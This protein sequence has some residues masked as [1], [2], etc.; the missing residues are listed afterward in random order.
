MRERIILA[1]GANGSELLK[2][3]AMH[4]V[5]CFN[6]RICSAPELAR[7]ALMRSGITITEEFISKREETVITANAIKGVDYFSTAT[8][9]DVQ[10]VSNAIRRLRSFV[11]DGEKEE[12]IIA[13]KLSLGSF[14]EKNSALVS[15]Y[16]NYMRQISEEKKIDTISLVRKAISECEPIEADYCVLDEFPLNPIEET[17]LS[18]LSKN[19]IQ[20]IELAALFGANDDTPIKINTY[21]RCYGASNEVETILADI[22]SGKSLDKC[23][24]AVTDPGTY[25]QLFFDYAILNDIPVSFGCGIPIINSNPAKLLKVYYH[26]IMGGFFGASAITS[27]LNSP[28]FDSSKL[29]GLYP[30]TDETFSWKTYIDVVKTIRLTNN[31]TDNDKRISDFVNSI[32]EEENIIGSEDIKDR[33]K[34]NEKKQCIPLLKVLS[35]ELSLPAEEFISKY[36]YIRKGSDT[37][38]Q[39]LLMRLDIAASKAIY[40]ELKI[41]RE[42]GVVQAT[43]DMIRN[44][45]KMSVSGERSEEGKLFVTSID[46]AMSVAR[47]NLF[48]A[49]LSASKYPES[50]IEN[51]LLLDEDI[52]LFGEKVD[53][54]TS[55]GRVKRKIDCLHALVKLARGLGSTIDIS[56]AG[57]NVSELK[58]DN[59]SSLIFEL[60][61]KE[62]GIN[63]TSKELEERIIKIDYF[64]PAISVTREVGK[65]Y[66]EGKK[67]L[68]YTPDANPVNSD[69]K[70]TLDK[71]YSPSTLDTFFGCP[72]AFMLGHI[73]GIPKP[74]EDKPFEI[75]SANELGTLAH[76]LMEILGNSDMSLEEFMKLSSDCFDRFVTQHPP[77]LVQGVENEKDQFLDM[78]ENAYKM[79]PHREVVLKE[80]DIS[81]VHETGVSL[82]GFPDRVEKLDDGSYLVV[83]FKSGKTISHVDDDINTCLQTMVY[84]YILEKNGFENVSGA[85]YRYIRL[86][87]TVSCRYDDKMKEDLSNMLDYFKQ[88]VEMADFPIN[89][90]AYEENREKGE[91]DPC[92]FCKYGLVCGK[93]QS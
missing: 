50:A 21:K 64:E 19:T 79:D 41:I 10:E 66:N 26:W 13:E 1:P 65:A 24:V 63:A 56:Y 86:G 78:M 47:E 74:D 38:T 33:C 37:N 53:H 17:F 6:L 45:L 3:L 58:K 30:E 5:N 90:K 82:H 91:K 27:L 87:Q 11:V 88:H 34:V 25:G 68:L 49:G 73:L 28:A 51:Y 59:A 48:I 29:K 12:Q 89:P 67:L 16:K 84:A 4:G 54:L 9:S 39:Q 20:N 22:Y 77:L 70:L 72:R 23:V 44:V 43:D 40:E 69:I 2:S 61:R 83:D 46:G 76:S 31:K 8:F 81:C 42:S 60:F 80:K 55:K 36:S 93:D 32:E 35:E 7:I 75:I 18:K 15:V 14:Q 92:F 85:E 62:N 57:L 52:R 71:E